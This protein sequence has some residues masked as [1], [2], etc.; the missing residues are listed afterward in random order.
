MKTLKSHSQIERLHYMKKR[1]NQAT[2]TA[3][4]VL[5][6]IC[7]TSG[8]AL[9]GYCWTQEDFSQSAIAPKVN[10]A[11]NN[12]GNLNAARY[13]HTATLL[14]SGN[15]LVAGGSSGK[16]VLNSAEFYD[17]DTGAWSITGNL[18][19]A[20]AGHTAT[21]LPNGKILVAG[22][23][24]SITPPSF[25]VTNSAE[26]FDPAAGTWSTTG[27]LNTSHTGHTA[28]LLPNGKVLVTAGWSGFFPVK[29]A[30]LYDP[31]TGTWTITGSLIAARYWHTATLLQNGKVLVAAGSDDGDLF[32]ALAS[33]ELYDPGTGTWS[34]TASLSDPRVLHTA[35]LLQNGK[36]LVADGYG[37]YVYG[38]SDSEELYDSTTGEWTQTG[39]VKTLRYGHTS[40]LLPN[41]NVVVS[42]GGY[43]NPGGP[44]NFINS[45]ELYD[46]ATAI[47]YST[48]EL[49]TARYGHTSTLLS[50][51]KVLLAGGYNGGGALNSAELYGAA[52]GTI[53][54]PKIV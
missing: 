27:S 17:A 8:F 37:G 19:S 30:E 11:R 21:L 47:W 33:A 32:T 43:A 10:S 2:Q 9:P 3:G 36:V 6:L 15:V 50:N 25:G 22:G 20:R 38:E 29:S 48:D 42:G 24:T 49:N 12:T 39:S 23:N 52:T 14:P 28:T 44:V 18:N 45:A 34:K 40:T 46:P 1:I 5:A 54:I 7:L 51:G 16:G 53:A 13:S 26:L 31:D 4:L 35:T 41:G